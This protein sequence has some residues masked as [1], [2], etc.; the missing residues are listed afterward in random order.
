MNVTTSVSPFV[1]V[2][3]LL[4]LCAATNADAQPLSIGVRG[5]YQYVMNE[6]TLPVVPG[7]TDCGA[8]ANGVSHGYFGGLTAEYALLDGL[9]E[10]GGGLAYSFRPATLTA[11]NNGDFEVFDPTTNNY[12]PLV[13]EHTYQADLGYLVF[14]GIVRIKPLA[15]L[16]FYVRLAVD[17]GNPIVQSTFTQTE[18][19]LSP[20]SAL[21]PN[22][23]KTRTNGSGEVPGTTTSFGG[24]GFI[25]AQIP[26]SKYVDLCPEVGYRMGFN[27][28][29]TGE[30]WK[31]NIA[32]GA[33]QIRYHFTEEEAA[34]PP[35]PP[36]PPPLPV[37]APVAVVVEA[38][39]PAP[40]VPPVT[41]TALS[42][43]PLRIRE[44]VVTQ[45]YPLLPYLFF[46]AGS[47]DLRRVY[48]KSGPVSGF[49]EEALPKSTLDI[50]YTM[51]DVIGSRMQR[52]N[53]KLVVTGTTDG[54]E[55]ASPAERTNLAAARARSVVSYMS[56]RWNLPASRFEVKTAERPSIASNEKY[57]E[58]IE[59]NRRVELHSTDASLLG[60]IVHTRFNEYVPE[61][62]VQE[63]TVNVLHPEQATSWRLGV[64]RH[65]Q[66]VAERSS[67]GAVP[68]RVQFVLDQNTTD[69]IG[70]MV[71]AED[72]LDARLVVAQTDG[73]P[74][75][76]D[77]QFPLTKTVSK[78]EVSR[79]SLIVFDF[80]QSSI[81]AANKEM[82][83][84]VISQSSREGTTAVIVGSTDRLG[85]LSHNMSLSQDRARS[86]E[87]HV[88]AVAPQVK[89]TSVSGIGPSQL[90][91]DN[92]TPEGRFYCR[93]VTLTLTTPLQSNDQR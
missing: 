74:V 15:S 28:I 26:L 42:T 58:G 2:V 38:P 71:N 29:V 31:Q 20:S 90:S 77:C 61:Q 65:G 40:V 60:P 91:Y 5:G 12:A 23:Q 62:P 89:I 86:V 39:P 84:R 72:T 63:F 78:F 67:A 36:P 45:T 9:L 52:S 81:S 1:R 51:L 68:Q 35:P 25:G 7:S 50:Y 14:E 30:E 93:T 56:Q 64:A 43:T 27:S 73:P 92:S 34:P 6:S 83:N 88:N 87:Q 17:A 18:E 53:D 69:R 22:G 49:K 33:I 80:D 19:I 11:T 66:E 10:L 13:R 75:E 85:E 21:F 46:D 37:P 76:G 47:S 82:M 8:F 16:P 54:I 41:I 3:L 70:P 79:L 55:A 59:E 32:I 44:T 24:G 48:R 4:T 57:P